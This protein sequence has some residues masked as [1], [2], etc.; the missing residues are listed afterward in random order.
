MPSGSAERASG[1][2]DQ[3][4]EQ[5]HEFDRGVNADCDCGEYGTTT[6]HT[7]DRGEN[8]VAAMTLDERRCE[9]RRHNRGNCPNGAE[10]ADG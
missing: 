5:V 6:A 9:R 1:T 3:R 7:I 10:E 8:A 4:G 2:C